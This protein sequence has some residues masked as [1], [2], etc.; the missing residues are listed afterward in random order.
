MTQKGIDFEKRKIHD[1]IHKTIGFSELE[2]EIINSRVFQ[3]LRNIKQLGLINYVF[4]GADYSRFSHSIGVCHLTGKIFDAIHEKKSDDN[5]E[6]DKQIA[7][8]A[9]LLHDVGHYPFSHAME[10]A[11][12]SHVSDEFGG[13][14]GLV[15]KD[16]DPNEDSYTPPK[17]HF[18]HES[19]AREILLHDQ[20]IQG[21]LNSFEIEPKIEPIE[22]YQLFTRASDSPIPEANMIS[23]DLDADRLD[24]LLRSAYHIGLPYGSTDLEYIL[25]QIKIDKD[26]NICISPKALRT[27]DHFLLCRYFDY[28]QVIFH[29]TV[30]GFE[31][32]LK[33]T[34]KYLIT[35]DTIFYTPES[36]IE[37]IK[38]GKWY[39]FDDICI[40]NL[41]KKH[42]NSEK[43]PKEI[44]TLMKSITER[45]PPKEI[46]KLEYLNETNDKQLNYFRSQVSDFKNIK[47]SISETFQIPE[48]YIFVWD[49]GGLEITKIGKTVEIS[50]T[51]KISREQ[52]DKLNQTVRIFDRITQT[53]VPIME[54]EDSLM[55]VLS[56]KALYSI[57]IFILFPEK[58]QE[59]E[60]TKIK[61]FIKDKLPYRDWK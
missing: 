39:E 35:N 21:I 45:N 10:D 14:R 37:A 50:K 19:V 22:I 53:S 58:P 15:K 61:V 27:I 8:L 36:I 46:V 3:R 57:R 59:E 60:I 43:T 13:L 7:R 34:I 17:K 47:R 48:D 40:L 31:E 12:K 51:Q 33:S 4:P 54:R 20:E 38:T 6:R 41:I 52:I 30:A 29:K 32:V 25:R 9:G 26:R 23:S 16:T 5:T 55:S 56:G 44:I 11:I 2:I 42:V 18:N 1:P 24:Y 49:N 28:S